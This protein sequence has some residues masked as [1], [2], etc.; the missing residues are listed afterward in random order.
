MKLW[1]I[2]M[3]GAAVLTFVGTWAAL[4]WL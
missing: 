2:G 4:P 3:A 1:W